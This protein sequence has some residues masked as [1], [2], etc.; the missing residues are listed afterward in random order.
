MPPLAGTAILQ[1]TE[2][3]EAKQASTC[4]S[5]SFVGM[6]DTS[7]G[8]G[9]PLKSCR[10]AS[11]QTKQLHS[12]QSHTPARLARLWACPTHQVAEAHPSKA[13]VLQVSKPNNYTAIKA[14]HLHVS[15]VCGHAR[16]IRWQRPTPQ[17][18]PSCKSP[19]QTITQQSKPHTC[20]S[21]SFVGMPDTSGG[22]DPSYRPSC[23]SPATCSAP[24]ASS[25][26]CS[27]AWLPPP[28]LL[29]WLPL[30]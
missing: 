13:A 26:C 27:C 7:G 8:R 17:K 10:P 1:P 15:L 6:P 25:C 11:L 14:T 3:G 16:H 18:L 12:N 30:V 5:R 22:R 23:S 21:R 19:N 29:P 4:T 2:Q 9:P 28:L 20:T 24:A